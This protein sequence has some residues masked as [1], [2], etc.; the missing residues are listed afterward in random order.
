MGDWILMFPRN[1]WIQLPFDGAS[2]P[3]TTDSSGAL[4]Q[5]HPNFDIL[6]LWDGCIVILLLLLLLKH[7]SP[8]WTLASITV[9]LCFGQSQTIDSQFFTHIC[10][11][12]SISS[13]SLFT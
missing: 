4:L 7:Y 9:F 11:F 8:L 6:C 1:I 10:K 5:K 3:K 2:C 12:S 13:L